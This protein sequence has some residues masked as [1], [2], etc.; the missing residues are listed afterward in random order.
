M[1]RQLFEDFILTP[2]F[3]IWFTCK[4]MWI[5][6]LD[7]QLEALKFV[8]MVIYELEKLAD[9]LEQIKNNK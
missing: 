5:Y 6:I 9:E 3:I 7:G 8:N 4:L 1:I 2:L